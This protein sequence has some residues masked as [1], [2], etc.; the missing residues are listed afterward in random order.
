MNN[1]I[2]I[3]RI[4]DFAIDFMLKVWYNERIG[5]LPC[6]LANQRDAADLRTFL[7]NPRMEFGEE[8]KFLEER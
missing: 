6:P 4:H 1:L 3:L 7:G 8:P 5:W 2:S